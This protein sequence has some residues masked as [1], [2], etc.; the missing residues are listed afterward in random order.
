MDAALAGVIVV[1]ILAVVV[2]VGVIRSRGWFRGEIHGP[3]QSKASVEGGPPAGVRARKIRAGRNV[4]ARGPGVDARC[5]QAGR[6]V[7]LDAN[8]PPTVDPPRD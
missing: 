2:V 4:D 1:S 3:G 8:P 6:D 7:N 5:V